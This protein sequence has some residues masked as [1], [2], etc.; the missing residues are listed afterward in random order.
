MSVLAVAAAIAI[1]V[2]VMMSPKN[3]SASKVMDVPLPE[4]IVQ[5]NQA[6]DDEAEIYLAGGC[7]WG[8][9]FLMRNV[10]GVTSVEVGYSN[11]ATRN[12]T[13][14]EVC[15]GSGHAESAHIIYNTN[16]VSLQ[17][18]LDIYFQ[19]IDPTLVNHQGKAHGDLLQQ[20]R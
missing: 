20:S 2:Y 12:P 6:G 1:G 9:E 19:S 13:Y 8:T 4:E 16:Y 5:Q 17:K 3:I 11:G 18:I 7:F 15:K 10:A 14:R